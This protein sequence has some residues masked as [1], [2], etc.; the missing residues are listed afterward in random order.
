[1]LKQTEYRKIFLNKTFLSSDNTQVKK[2]Q[3]R[4]PS[5]ACFAAIMMLTTALS[6]CGFSSPYKEGQD[7]LQNQAQMD[8]SSLDAKLTARQEAELVERIQSGKADLFSLFSNAVILGDSRVYG[9]GSY[10]YLRDDQVFAEAGDTIENISDSAEQ[11]KAL[12]PKVI[13]LSY[14]VND[15]G[16]NIGADLGEDGYRQVYEEQI[17]TLLNG[18]PGSIIAVNSVIPPTPQTVEAKPRWGKTEDFNRQIQQMCEDK[19]WVY[20]DNNELAE[21]GNAEI[22]QPDGIHFLDSFYP[23]W[24]ENMLMS[25]Y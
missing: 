16:L 5:A 7:Y 13:Y 8:I 19:G 20:I 18:S 25:V 24:A 6:G 11:I 17:N 12:K 15:M 3:I 2:H 23:V 21:G 22:Y 10:G 1:M 14:G 9:F 4:K